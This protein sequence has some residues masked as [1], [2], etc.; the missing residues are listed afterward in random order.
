MRTLILGCVVLALLGTTAGAV[1]RGHPDSAHVQ[2]FSGTAN[3]N[4]GTLAV[5]VWTGVVAGVNPSGGVT[6]LPNALTPGTVEGLQLV[7]NTSSVTIEYRFNSPQIGYSSVSG[8]PTFVIYFGDATL[9]VNATDSGLLQITN[10]T[11]STDGG[12]TFGAT[13]TV[14]R[15]LPQSGVAGSH[16]PLGYY[17]TVGN[18]P[19]AAVDVIRM[20]YTSIG[21]TTTQFWLAGLQ[22][23]EPATFALFGLGILGAGTL[24]LRRRR[25]RRKL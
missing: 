18:P 10:A 24:V 13:Q 23:P 9:G 16:K 5:P 4:T 12:A 25:L 11:F 20:T 22:N 17:L 2:A 8:Y 19:L 7:G 15:F 6:V 3:V 1:I 21:A 14:N